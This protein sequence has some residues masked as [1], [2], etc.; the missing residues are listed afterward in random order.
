MKQKA[1][2]LSDKYFPK[3]PVAM[4][5]VILLVISVTLGVTAKR[6]TV[7]VVIDGKEKKIVTY[8]KCLGKVLDDNNIKIGQDDKISKKLD[9]EVKDGDKV[10]IKKAVDV[11]LRVDGKNLIVKTSEDSVEDMLN[12][13]GI[14]INKQDRVLPSKEQKISDGLDVSVVRVTSKVIKEN[15]ELNFTTVVKKDNNLQNGKKKVIQPGKKGEKTISTKVVFEDGKEVSR[16]VVGESISKK[17]ISQVVAVG[18]M[19]VARPS[20]GVGSSFN[21]RNVMKMRATAY[22]ADEV[23][24]GKG[25]G[26]PYFGITATGTRAKRN[27]NGYS[28]IAVDPRVIPLGTKVYVEGYGLAIAEDVGGAIKGNRIDVFVN[29]VSQANTWG[30]R[31]VN[32]YILK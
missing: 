8:K 11:K 29:T 30:V 23:C 3:G 14:K 7:S 5:V 18:T 19:Q 21:Y 4:L 2:D 28:T 13:E 26:D 31:W 12:K 10:Y 9:C 16:K 24:T 32:V 6:K 15:K 27:P 17:P 25:S 1:R 20:R 22:S